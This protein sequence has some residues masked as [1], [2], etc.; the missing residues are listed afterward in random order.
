VPR[1]GATNVRDYHVME[2]ELWLGMIHYGSEVSNITLSLR[3]M[4]TTYVLYGVNVKQYYD[5]RSY[6]T[7]TTLLAS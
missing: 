1:S 6:W 3:W 7:S 2:M 5:L 4:H